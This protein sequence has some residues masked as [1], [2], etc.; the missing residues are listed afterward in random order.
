[1]T[2]RFA[3]RGLLAVPLAILAGQEGGFEI[4]GGTITFR[5]TA[6]SREYATL[7]NRI[8]GRIATAANSG[9]PVGASL[10]R[11]LGTSRLPQVP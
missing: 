5:D 6:S 9:S 2:D 10:A 11:V 1:M 7:R 8:N 4:S 3:L